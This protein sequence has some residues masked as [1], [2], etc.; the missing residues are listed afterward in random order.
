MPFKYP[1]L[2]ARLDANSHE[3]PAPVG[4]GMRKFRKPCRIWDGAKVMGD[5]PTPYG[6][7]SARSRMRLPRKRGQKKGTR[8]LRSLLAH[9]VSKA[10]SLGVSIFAKLNHCLHDCGRSLCIE[11]EHIYSRLPPRMAIKKNNRDTVKHGHH[12]NMHGATA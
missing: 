12:R 1:S 3:E 2:R 6:K 4:P 10:E 8:R 5:R 7:F 9:R 11:P